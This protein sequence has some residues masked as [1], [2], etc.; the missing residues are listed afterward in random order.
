MRTNFLRLSILLILPILLGACVTYVPITHM[1]PSKAKI[2]ENVQ[3]IGILAYEYDPSTAD[4]RWQYTKDSVPD[5]IA[6][7]ITSWNTY[8]VVE[9]EKLQSLMKEKMMQQTTIIDESA[10]REIGKFANAQALLMG[11]INRVQVV[12][13]EQRKKFTP[14]SNDPDF[15]PQPVIYV[16]KTLQVTLDVTSN[17]VAVDDGR[18]FVTDKFSRT[19]NSDRDPKVNRRGLGLFDDSSPEAQAN[20]YRNQPSRVPATEEVITNLIHQCVQQVIQKISGYPV[21]HE[22]PLMNSGDVDMSSGMDWVAKGNYEEAIASFMAA[23]SKGGDIGFAA[24]YNAGVCNEALHNYPQAQEAYEKSLEQ[25]NSDEAREALTR[26][27]RYYTPK[28]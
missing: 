17:F 10:A 4:P 28:K 22:V 21:K 8:E 24:W 27:K 15:R 1:A 16:H 3:R 19:Y 13:Q 11:R 25:R 20:Y 26:L 9:R 12:E 7:K 2:P 6:S 18:K 5:E 14:T 23:T